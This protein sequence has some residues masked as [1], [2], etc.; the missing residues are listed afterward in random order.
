MPRITI[1]GYSRL[2]PK[3]KQQV[4]MALGGFVMVGIVLFASG[5]V[6]GPPAIKS[7][8]TQD[9][10]KPKP[11][12]AVPGAALDTKDAW[13]GA[14]GKDL[15]RMRDDLKLQADEV[16]HQREEQER[17][18][19]E[20]M[21]ELK[22]MREGRADTAMS[23]VREPA[24]AASASRPMDRT[25]DRSL[26]RPGTPAAMGGSSF[27]AQ[28]RSERLPAP[29][30]GPGASTAYPPGTPNRAAGT[31][32]PGAGPVL[33][34]EQTAPVVLRVSLRSGGGRGEG[35]EATGTG[36][37]GG[38]TVPRRVDNFLPVSFTRAV[39]LGGLAAPTGGQAQAN[40]VP[41]LLRLMDAAVLPN[42]FRSQVKDCLVIGEGFGDQSAERAYIRTTLLSCVMR[43]GRVMEIPLKGSVFG[44]DGMNGMMGKLVTKQGQ[45]L[46]NA[47]LAG[48]ASGLGSG[49]AQA[50]QTITTSPLGSTTTTGTDAKS[51]VQAGVGTGVG[52]AL[53]RLSQYYIS[54]AEKTF[55]V[56]EILPGRVVDIVVTQGAQL[57]ATLSAGSQL[58]SRDSGND[59]SKLMQAVR[60]DDED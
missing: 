13:V 4:N 14:A 31:G 51:I 30:Q 3:R 22:A 5:F 1:P 47:L 57:D 2:S 53:D 16:R 33:A 18:N 55:P 9:A 50:S 28:P 6:G 10:P 36:A 32:A 46:T 35:A 44:E 41:V 8:S 20:L 17:I 34:A 38:A 25:S 12:G 54:L 43:D 40:P 29:V 15:T 52:K 19:K 37:V 27:P 56:I 60:T 45:I 7:A 26:D 39:L 23:A 59:R 48:I 42:Q 58:A 21:A 24:T 11:L 49:L